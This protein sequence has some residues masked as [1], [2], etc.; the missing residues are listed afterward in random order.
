M[1]AVYRAPAERRVVLPED[2]VRDDERP[3]VVD[4][5]VAAEVGAPDGEVLEDKRRA[6]FDHDEV[7]A[8]RLVEN[9]SS[10]VDEPVDL[11]RG[12]RGDDVALDVLLPLQ[13]PRGVE[14][15]VGGGGV[16]AERFVE[17][18][19][20]VVVA[21]SRSVAPREI[22]AEHVAGAHGHGRRRVSA[23]ERDALRVAAVAGVDERDC[24]SSL[25]RPGGHALG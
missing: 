15:K 21:H 12:P 13:R 25:G 17:V 23:T 11:H 4:E 5:A 24:V 1:V 20:R 19:L 10:G 7:P 16:D 8:R 3:F 9:R 22:P 2:A 14:R 18:A 6:A